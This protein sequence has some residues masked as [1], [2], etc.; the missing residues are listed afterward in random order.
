MYCVQVINS[1]TSNDE[2]RNTTNSSC[3]QLYCV[4]VLLLADEDDLHDVRSAVADLSGRWQ[5]L[6]VSLGIRQ[7]NL[8]AIISDNPHSSSDYYLRKVLTLWLRQNYKVHVGTNLSLYL[9]CLS[10]LFFRVNC[11]VL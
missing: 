3:Q 10:D 2:T 4:C 8:K 7:D 11:E 9:L 6:G 1:C 5:D